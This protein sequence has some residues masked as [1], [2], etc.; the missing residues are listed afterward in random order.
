MAERKEIAIALIGPSGAGKT[1]LVYRVVQNFPKTKLIISYTTR[2]PRLRPDGTM[3]QDG[4]DYF[5]VSK[6]KFK[7]LK[8][9]GFFFESSDHHDASYGTPKDQC[10]FST[11]NIIFDVDPNGARELKKQIPDLIQIFIHPESTLSLSRRL[12]KRGGLTDDKIKSRI[13]RYEDFER[14]YASECDYQ[15][16]N[17]DGKFKQ[18][19]QKWP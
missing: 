12:Y 7:K 18:F 2:K 19:L 16:T 8:S 6:T 5:F 11:H 14:L 4:V 9:Q 13:K 15:F 10:T 17:Y 3:E 1:S